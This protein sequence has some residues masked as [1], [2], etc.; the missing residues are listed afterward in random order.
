MKTSRQSGPLVGVKVLEL[1]QIMAGPICGTLLAD[2]GAEVIKVEKIPGGDDTRRYAEPQINGES[3][4]FMILNR[5]KRSV[6][7]NLKTEGGREVLRRLVKDADVVVENYRKGTMEKL[8]VG[9]ESLRK[10]NPALIWCSISGYGLTGPYAAR[11]GF[12]LIAQGMS[13]IM[14]ITGEPGRPPVKSGSPVTDINA[15][16]L[17]ALGIV[18]AYVHRLQT[19]E[20][21]L[22]DTSLMEAGIQQ[23]FWQ[24]AMYFATGLSPGP[25]GSAHVLTAPYQAFPTKDGWI[26]IGGANQANWE[27]IATTVGA[28]EL[29]DDAHF[30]T[31]SDRMAH[32]EELTHI[33]GERLKQRTT[34]EWLADFD[35]AGVPAGPINDIAAMV[36][37]PQTLAR[38]MVVELDHPKT[39]RTRALGLPLKFSRTPGKVVHPAPL[40]GQHTRE[41]L[42][43]AGYSA[44]E[45]VHLAEA[46]AIGLG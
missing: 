44:K 7:I 43:A 6:A 13:G 35:A 30:K 17:A 41:V 29:V 26:N 8:G 19:G 36:S 42:S 32:R 3:A 2:M 28:P 46:G 5:N 22:V 23:T 38:E 24:S 14:S 33:L 40:L 45:I 27:R 12:D 37:D 18:S 39:G 9:Y 4:A 16:I 25:T 11:G 15:G 21:Q 1:A 31:N 20:G 10:I 34:Q